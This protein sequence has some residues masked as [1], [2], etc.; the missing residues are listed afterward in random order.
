MRVLLKIQK[1]EPP[2]L[3]CPSLWSKQFQDFIAKCLTKDPNQR[4]TAPELLEHP[5]LKNE[6]SA[7]KRAILAVISEYK[8]EVFEEVIL[9]HDEE[10]SHI[11]LIVPHHYFHF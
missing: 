7:D 6:S 10:V 8:A 5:F 4:P 1:G 9:V 2:K 11:L 3:E